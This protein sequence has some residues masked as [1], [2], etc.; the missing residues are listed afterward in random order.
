MRQ[1]ILRKVKKKMASIKGRRNDE[2][3]ADGSGTS[4]VA[5]SL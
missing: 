3:E 4:R 1:M 2:K 5:L